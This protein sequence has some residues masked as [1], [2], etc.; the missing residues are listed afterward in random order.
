M[1]RQLR[2]LCL[3]GLSLAR[4]SPSIYRLVLLSRTT[5]DTHTL[6]LCLVRYSLSLRFSPRS[7]FSLVSISMIRMP[8]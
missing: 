5:S 3:V 4:A 6:T 2:L 1:R 8:T 7:G